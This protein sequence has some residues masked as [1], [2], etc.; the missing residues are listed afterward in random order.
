MVEKPVH[1]VFADEVFEQF[2]RFTPME[3]F[4]IVAALKRALLGHLD[5]EVKHLEARQK[6]DDDRIGHIKGFM[7]KLS[8]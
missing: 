8:N 6:E 1:I 3:Q 4:E 5:M 7:Q 2:E